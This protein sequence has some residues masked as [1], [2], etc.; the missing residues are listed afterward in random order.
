M[1]DRPIE[2]LREVR[3]RLGD[4][5][6]QLARVLAEQNTQRPGFG[7]SKPGSTSGQPGPWRSTERLTGALGAFL[8]G[9][10]E[11][12][13]ILRNVRELD[14]ALGQFK[15][16]WRG[17][18]ERSTS[19]DHPSLP[20]PET[21]RTTPTLPHAVT[22]SGPLPVPVVLTNPPRLS[23]GGTNPPRLPSPVPPRPTVPA[24]VRPILPAPQ[25]PL[26]APVLSPA[27][28]QVPLPAPVL[29]APRTPHRLRP[30]P[31]WSPPRSPTPPAVQPSAL[32]PGRL[33]PP[34][35][36]TTPAVQSMPRPVAPTPLFGS[37][38]ASA[39]SATFTPAL[40]GLLG[41]LAELVKEARALRE[42][43][44]QQDRNEAD[45]TDDAER[46]LGDNP[47]PARRSMWRE[48]PAERSTSN[49]GASPQRLPVPRGPF[50]PARRVPSASEAEHGS[51]GGDWMTRLGRTLNAL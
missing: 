10:G 27:P 26:P 30:A 46:K 8:P 12:S 6:A 1:A 42:A 19:S 5:P 4:L 49:A 18:E 22:L 43:Y 25:A 23:G 48:P 35:P 15:G 38:A 14:D 2:V 29:L 39:P 50:R 11:L 47:E 17:R 45:G 28:R 40:Q 31:T 21:P 33:L 44:E 32:V 7:A 24:P 34:P 9:F 41:M 37:G 51:G 20:R 3:D 13:S 16:A 36:A